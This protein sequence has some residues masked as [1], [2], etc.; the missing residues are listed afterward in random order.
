M[1]LNPPEKI[2]SHRG[3]SAYAPENTLAA[4]NKALELG[5]HYI[6]F[7]VMLSKDEEPFVFHDLFLDRT[8]NGHGEFAATEANDLNNLDAGQWFSSDFYSEKI[9]HFQKVLEWLN[10]HPVQA[11]IELKPSPGTTEQTAIIVAEHLKKHWSPEKPLPLIS[12]FDYIAL[13]LFKKLVPECPLGLLIHTWEPNWKIL[14]EEIKATSI[15]INKWILTKTRVKAIKDAG[16][17]VLAYTVNRKKQAE[18]LLHWG[19]DAIFSDYP[20]LLT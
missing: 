19:V 15:N 12:S 7:D 20:D 1:L 8:T 4:F 17:L 9:P 5:S 14:A 6:E 16:Y 13:K 11:N 3:A 2:I 10:H 18:K